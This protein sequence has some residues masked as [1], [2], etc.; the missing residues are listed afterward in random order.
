MTEAETLTLREVCA[1]LR[2]SYA[3][4]HRLIKRGQFPIQVMRVGDHFRFQRDDLERFLS[5]GGGAAPRTS[6]RPLPSGGRQ[7]RRAAAAA[8]LAWARQNAGVSQAELAKRLEAAFGER[9]N[10]SAVSRW[11]G[12]LVSLDLEQVRAVAVALGLAPADLFRRTGYL[13]M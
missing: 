13:T 10:Q 8:A 7:E 6:R 2:I 9:V 1:A 12:G 3:T 11:E 5:G 4:G